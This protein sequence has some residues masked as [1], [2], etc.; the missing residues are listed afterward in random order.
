[1]NMMYLLN[2]N[3]IF[4]KKNGSSGN[5]DVRVNHALHKD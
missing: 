2:K 3:G 4:L 5:I 1:M